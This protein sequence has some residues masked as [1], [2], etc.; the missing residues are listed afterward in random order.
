MI[1]R[2]HLNVRNFCKNSDIASL[3]RWLL[4]AGVAH[5]DDHEIRQLATE[6][7]GNLND[8]RGTRPS[9]GHRLL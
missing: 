5:Y 9:S 4:M 2:Q 1:R 6:A 3:H 8:T 7:L